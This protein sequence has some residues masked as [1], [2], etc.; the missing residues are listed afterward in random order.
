MELTVP[1]EVR[2]GPVC[3]LPS[4]GTNHTRVR[5]RRRDLSLDTSLPVRGEGLSSS[6]YGTTVHQP[7]LGVDNPLTS[8]TD[9]TDPGSKT[10]VGPLNPDT[11]EQR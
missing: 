2:P 9:F 3:T 4:R 5:S 1:S 8:P 7:R 6:V 11:Q 10:H